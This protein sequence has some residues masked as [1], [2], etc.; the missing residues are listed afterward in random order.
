MTNTHYVALD[1]E[2]TGIYPYK[3]DLLLQVAA[4][5]TDMN[6]TPLDDGIEFV[7]HF[8][9]E[10]AHEMRERAIPIVQDM[11]D[12]TGLWERLSSS[13]EGVT[14]EEGDA[15]LAEYLSAF[16]SEALY[17]LGNSITL[18]RNFME[19]FLP[20]S[21]ALLHYR[22]MDVTS[23][24]LFIENKFG[25]E[26]AEYRSPDSIVAHEAR[27]DILGSLEQVRFYTSLLE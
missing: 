20:K 7:I 23:V 3:D 2:T 9:K 18:D 19:V 5:V 4:Y 6:Y 10:K 1:T 26:K 8:P 21:F 24:R 22:S 17:L 12:R 27:A 11:H 14:Y 16:N 13:P 15:Q 25:K